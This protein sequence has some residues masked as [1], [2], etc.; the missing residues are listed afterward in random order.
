MNSSPITAILEIV[1][2]FKAPRQTVFD[3]FS[4][5]EVMKSWMGP[6]ACKVQGGSLDF[7]IGGEYHF[8][9]KTPMGET[10]VAGHY[11]EITPPEK[12]AFTWRWL[13]DSDWAPVDSLVVFEFKD[14]GDLTELRLRHTGFPSLESRD[15]H[16]QG[17]SGSLDK[18]EA[19]SA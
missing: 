2:T 19:L 5:F 18:L 16:Q 17:W 4:S 12:I 6:E 1:R 10:T 9:M 11:T 14:L 8:D 15:N 3:A 13:D 7:R